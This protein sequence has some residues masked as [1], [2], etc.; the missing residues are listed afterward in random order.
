[1]SLKQNRIL[2][3]TF[4]DSEFGVMWVYEFLPKGNSYEDIC[5]VSIWSYV[6]F[7]VSSNSELLWRRLLSLRLELC[8]FMSFKQRWILMETFVESQFRVMWVYE[9]QT[10]GKSSEDICW[11]SVSSYVNWSVSNKS[12][13]LWINLLT[14]SLKLCNFMK[15]KQKRILMKTFIESQFEVMWVSEFQTKANCYEDIFLV[16]VW[17]FLRLWDSSRSKFSRRHLLSLSFK[18]F[19]FMTFKQKGILMKTFVESQFEIF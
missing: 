15:F 19:K 8:K 1:M 11:G 9:F 3:M 13:F 16:S 10:K 6:R 2:K 12:E 4:V 7:G 17:S 14:L 18:L 5:W